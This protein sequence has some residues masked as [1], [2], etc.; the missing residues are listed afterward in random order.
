MITDQNLFYLGRVNHI[1]TSG[2]LS[3][4]CNLSNTMGQGT[5]GF[6]AGKADSKNDSTLQFEPGHKIF[7]QTEKHKRFKGILVFPFLISAL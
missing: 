5:S 4:Y 1:A 7:A 3:F 2:Y 6:I